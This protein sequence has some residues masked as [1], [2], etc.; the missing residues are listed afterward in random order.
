MTLIEGRALINWL[1]KWEPQYRVAKDAQISALSGLLEFGHAE[2]KAVYLWK[3]GRTYT[4]QYRALTSG[5][6]RIT[7][8]AAKR[9]TRAAFEMTSELGALRAVAELPGASGA[10]GASAVL[11][12]ANPQRYTVVA[13]RALASLEYLGRWS[14]R[15]QAGQA[16]FVSWLLYLDACRAL[17][18]E[19]N[20]SLRSIDRALWQA[21]GRP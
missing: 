13:W 7:D 12:A 3:Y 4:T 21:K 17:A 5:P 15:A 1:D 20:R 6:K 2:L 9:L 19:S 18:D 8:P 11:M 14:R 10:A 16:T